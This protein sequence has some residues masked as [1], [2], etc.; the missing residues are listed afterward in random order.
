MV[1]EL[2]T[3]DQSERRKIMAK[4]GI[5]MSF[6]LPIIEENGVKAIRLLDAC[7]TALDN[8]KAF[9]LDVKAIYENPEIVPPDLVEQVKRIDPC[10]LGESGI[11]VSYEGTGQLWVRHDESANLK[12]LNRY[13]WEVLQESGIEAWG[14]EYSDDCSE[15]YVGAFGGGVIVITKGQVRQFL[16]YDM[17]CMLQHWLKKD[18]ESALPDP[19]P[20][21]YR[22]EEASSQSGN[23]RKKLH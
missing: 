3:L 20:V 16:T 14:F 23:A 21:Q 5:K 19:G 2:T 7:K 4:H 9:S 18:G 10:E 11:I 15:P 6:N 17:L 8:Y 1:S 22:D 12:F 13:L